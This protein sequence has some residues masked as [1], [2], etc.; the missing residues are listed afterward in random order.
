MVPADPRRELVEELGLYSPAVF[1]RTE[2]LD[3]E[4]L[5]DELDAPEALRFGKQEHEKR[6]LTEDS[7]SHHFSVSD[8]SGEEEI[9]L[10]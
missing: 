3:L 10:D 6:L 2:P 5:T 9:I 7:P 1:R 4:D 8:T